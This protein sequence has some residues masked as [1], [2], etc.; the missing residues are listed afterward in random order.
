MKYTKPKFKIGDRVRI[1]KMM[2][3]SEKETNQFADEIFEFSAISTKKTSYIHHERS[4]KRRICG[5]I[6]R[7]RAEK[8]FKLEVSHF[9]I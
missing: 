2:F 9:L 7:E 8:V 5:N 3:R 6:L 4:R 1:S